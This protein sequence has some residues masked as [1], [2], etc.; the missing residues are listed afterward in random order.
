M[1]REKVR[2]S[3]SLANFAK[4]SAPRSSN[5]L[6]SGEFNTNIGTVTRPSKFASSPQQSPA[7][8]SSQSPSSK[9]PGFFRANSPSTISS[10]PTNNSSP[11]SPPAAS[12]P[13][14]SSTPCSV[15]FS[16]RFRGPRHDVARRCT[17]QQEKRAVAA[18]LLHFQ[19]YFSSFWIFLRNH[20]I[21]LLRIDPYLRNRLL[22]DRRFN[23]SI[24]R[25]FV[26]R[27]KRDEFRVHLEEIAQ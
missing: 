10:P 9:S 8:P 3:L 20:R 27:R 13:P 11:N 18:A 6:N 5:Q 21:P 2:K 22:H 26:Q 24:E 14:N 16:V 12:N 4:S 7:T 23:L 25:Q 1:K 17:T 15:R 19:F